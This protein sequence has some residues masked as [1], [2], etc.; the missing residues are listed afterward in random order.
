MKDWNRRP[1]PKCREDKRKCFAYHLGYCVVLNDTEFKR[2]CPFY[3]TEEE[4]IND[5]TGETDTRL[6]YRE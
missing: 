6:S 4:F 1:N 3:K 5:A 2:A